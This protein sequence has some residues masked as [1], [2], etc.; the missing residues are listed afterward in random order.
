VPETHKP[1][2]PPDA[3]RNCR[4]SK[5]MTL[6][7]GALC[8]DGM[9][10]C[11]DTEEGT[12]GGGKRD[13]HKLF[14]FGGSKWSM[15]IGTAGF[16]PLCDIAIKRID[17]T[18]R[19]DPD[20]FFA[21]H[22]TKLGEVIASLYQQYIP[23]TLP[24]WKQQERQISLVIGIN[25]R[26]SGLSDMFLYKTAEEILHPVQHKFECAGV[27]QE[28]AYYL[29][30]RIYDWQSLRCFEVQELLRFV[31]KEAKESVGNVGGNTEMQTINGKS[32]G[33][34]TSAFGAGWEGKLPRL[35]QNITKWWVD[36]SR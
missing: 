1:E 19:L 17:A 24:E 2:R 4:M 29:M 28:I 20:G 36:T 18:V 15:L 8:T 14:S 32:G 21:E 16:G 6:V 7:I 22:E 25:N 9:V 35:E 5:R 10:F 3:K 33:L 11:S 31:M 23:K 26:Q 30:D 27:G 13:V 34:V 12:A